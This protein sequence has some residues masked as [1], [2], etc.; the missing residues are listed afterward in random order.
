MGAMHTNP[1]ANNG[2]LFG[3]SRASARRTYMKSVSGASFKL[4]WAVKSLISTTG[5]LLWKMEE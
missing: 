1:R 2:R 4:I 3:H 5:L